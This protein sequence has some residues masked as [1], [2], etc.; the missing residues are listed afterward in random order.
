MGHVL[1]DE[2]GQNPG[3]QAMRQAFSR[4][5]RVHDALFDRTGVGW[6]DPLRPRLQKMAL[7][8][9]E[10]SYGLARGRGLPEGA[11]AMADFYALCL[12]R[13]LTLQGYAVADNML[14][15]DGNLRRLFEEVA[16]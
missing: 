5:E 1:L 11:S 10:R 2:W 14:P 9:F 3:V 8:L 4:M 13:V 16:P 15:A 7:H 12:A 6:R